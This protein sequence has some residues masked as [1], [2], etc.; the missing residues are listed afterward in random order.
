MHMRFAHYYVFVVL[1]S[2]ERVIKVVADRENEAP[3]WRVS[4][5]MRTFIRSLA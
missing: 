2:I 5:K 1:L 3:I 4:W